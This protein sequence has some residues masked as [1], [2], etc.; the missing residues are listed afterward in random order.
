MSVFGPRLA[1]PRRKT[2][3]VLALSF[4]LAA[5][6]LVVEPNSPVARLSG[7]EPALSAEVPEPAS[8]ALFGVGLIAAAHRLRRRMLRVDAGA[9]QL[10]SDVGDQPPAANSSVDKEF[11]STPPVER[12]R[13]PM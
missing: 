8:L 7:G 13:A 11:K 4:S 1:F 6:S 9:G 3:R 12:T 2:V 10:P 5:G